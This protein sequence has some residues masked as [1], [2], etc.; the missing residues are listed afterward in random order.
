MLEVVVGVETCFERFSCLHLAAVMID[1][2]GRRACRSWCGRRC[3]PHVSCDGPREGE[4][5]RSLPVNK[6]AGHNGS[7]GFAAA[8]V[9]SFGVYA[10]GVFAF[11]GFAIGIFAFGPRAVG[12]FA[13]GPDAVSLA[14]DLDA[15]AGRQGDVGQRVEPAGS[16]SVNP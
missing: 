3:V 5:C 9:F 8:G 10:A 6:T 7:I 12:V 4:E 2:N 15:L 11:G 1:G 14:R 16:R 13:F